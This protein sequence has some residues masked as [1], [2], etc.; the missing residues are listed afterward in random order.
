MGKRGSPGTPHSPPRSS[1]TDSMKKRSS[2]GTL[3]SP[4]RKLRKQMSGDPGTP[5]QEAITP[6]TRTLRAVQRY[7]QKWGHSP[8]QKSENADERRL[9]KRFSNVP[10]HRKQSLN[11]ENKADARRSHVEG[12]LHAC[13]AFFEAHGSA[14]Q[15][16]EDPTRADEQKLARKFD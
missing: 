7:K 16:T 6:N 12:T 2:A 15:I 9:A 4:P 5:P 14:P 1:K 10:R 8:S 3:D 13:F 11:A